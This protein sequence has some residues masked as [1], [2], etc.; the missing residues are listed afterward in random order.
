MN[1]KRNLADGYIKVA[2]NKTNYFYI[3]KINAKWYTFTIER[4]TETNTTMASFSTKKA[5]IA[6]ANCWATW[7]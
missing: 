6:C 2:E 4:E 7:M 3:K 1:L 5:A